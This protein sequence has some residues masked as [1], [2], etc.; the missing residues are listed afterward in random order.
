[1]ISLLVAL[2]TL[3]PIKE[4]FFPLDYWVLP[5]TVLF[6]GDV[7]V[8]APRRDAHPHGGGVWTRDLGRWRFTDP[9]LV[10]LDQ[11]ALVLEPTAYALKGNELLAGR[12][13]EI[14]EVATGTKIRSY[15][16]PSRITT[17]LQ[18]GADERGHVFAMT[19]F[20]GG[21]IQ[22]LKSGG[23]LGWEQV[24]SR[25]GVLKIC[26]PYVDSYRFALHG[27]YLIVTCPTPFGGQPRRVDVYDVSD[28]Y[29]PRLLHAIP[30]DND[31]HDLGE[32]RPITYDRWVIVPLKGRLAAFDLATGAEVSSVVP[33]EPV[34]RGR[35]AA[36][37]GDTLWVAGHSK[38]YGVDLSGLP[39]RLTIGAPTWVTRDPEAKG[40]MYLHAQGAR[41]HAIYKTRLYGNDPVRGV[42]LV[43][44]EVE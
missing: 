22:I 17:M 19:T 40:M 13:S 27:T 9:G 34:A 25:E 8:L 37:D 15:D 36:L 44:Y 42:A 18:L 10:K 16:E 20:K 23:L 11:R 12:N 2:S 6:D 31:A 26:Q 35:N 14:L 29:E 28:V 21:S 5:E 39:A 32:W 30:L 33:P 38:I 7:A 3:T 1:M 4:E 24:L 41:L 43:T